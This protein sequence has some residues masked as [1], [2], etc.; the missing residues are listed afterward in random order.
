MRRTGKATT[1]VNKKLVQPSSLA[2]RKILP[3]VGR[4]TKTGPV[5]TSSKE[6][7]D[8]IHT[9]SNAH[10]WQILDTHLL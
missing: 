3:K 5:P 9:V 4:Q 10:A 7:E 2:G 6:V 8:T 1:R